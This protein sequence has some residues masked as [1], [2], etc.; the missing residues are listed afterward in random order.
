MIITL[1]FDKI[2][3]RKHGD[4]S[5][6]LSISY[7]DVRI[8]AMLEGSIRQEIQKCVAYLSKNYEDVWL[9]PTEKHSEK[10]D[11]VRRHGNDRH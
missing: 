5:N 2:S 1:P 11:D 3:E 8:H 4:T 10:T 6:D 7:V 9:K